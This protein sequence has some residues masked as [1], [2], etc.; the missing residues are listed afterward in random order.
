MDVNITIVKLLVYTEPFTRSL[1]IILKGV[2]I[3]NINVLLNVRKNKKMEFWARIWKVISKVAQ[4]LRSTAKSVTSSLPDKKFSTTIASN[5]SNFCSNSKN[6][7]KII[8]T[9]NLGMS[10]TSLLQ[11]V[12]VGI[13]SSTSE[14]EFCN[15]RVHLNVIY[16]IRLTSITMKCFIIVTNASM[17]FVGHALS[18][19]LKFLITK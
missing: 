1:W 17:T 5:L 12:L 16:A 10:Q 11:N 2:Y 19:K 6:T 4:R 13:N 18:F 9:S 3:Q 14:D 8:L 15:I 7:K